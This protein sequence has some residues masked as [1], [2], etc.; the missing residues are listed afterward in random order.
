M[1]KYTIATVYKTYGRNKLFQNLD[2]STNL[3]LIVSLHALISHS[4]GRFGHMH[5]P[6]FVQLWDPF[7]RYPD[8]VPIFPF[9]F[10]WL[11]SLPEVHWADGH[12]SAISMKVHVQSKTF[13]KYL[14]LSK[15]KQV[16]QLLPTSHFLHDDLVEWGG[17]G[18]K[19]SGL[20]S[21]SESSSRKL[22]AL[23]DLFDTIKHNCN[24][25]QFITN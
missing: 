4:R 18:Y 17:G 5:G 25:D 20:L 2:Q 1:Y 8:F 22:R 15:D 16:C 9:H 21:S 11:S 24:T 10:Y 19:I 13:T 3:S 6:H 14:L 23:S 7:E 12:G